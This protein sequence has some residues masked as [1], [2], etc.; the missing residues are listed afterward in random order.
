M[1]KSIHLVCAGAAIFGFGGA[2][3]GADAPAAGT[4][5]MHHAAPAKGAKSAQ[6]D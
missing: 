2:A 4:P 5:A 6:T 1:S 3:W